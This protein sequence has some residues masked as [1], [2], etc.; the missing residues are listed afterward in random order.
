MQSQP[1]AAPRQG[2]STLVVAA[3]VLIVVIQA[4]VIALMGRALWFAAPPAI[5]VQTA[6][7][8]EKVM[9]SSTP[10][11][12][13]PMR[14]SAA[15]D[16]SWISVTSPSTAGVVGAKAPATR[17]GIVRISSPISLKVVEN[18]RTIGSVPGGDLKLAPGRHEIE[19]VNVALGYRLPQSVLVEAG[20]TVSIHVAP[21]NG[22]ATIYAVPSAEVSIDGKAVGRTPLGP[23]PLALGHHTVTFTHPTGASDRQ[24]ISVKSG[25][26]IRVIGNPRR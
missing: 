24:R 4:G 17:T 18:S 15:P 5:A 6:P 19:L 10:A 2:F 8:G 25:E 23:L 21:A 12:S 13:N 3:L 14:L 22:W 7:S 26:T 11:E 16:L 20:Q 1:V 9:V